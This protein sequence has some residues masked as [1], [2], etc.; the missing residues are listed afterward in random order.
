M[1]QAVARPSRTPPAQQGLPAGSSTGHEPAAARPSLGELWQQAEGDRDRYLGLLRDHG[2]ARARA[3]LGTILFDVLAIV[4]HEQSWVGFDDATLDDGA[5]AMAPILTDELGKHGYRIHDVARCIRPPVEELGRPMTP[6][7]QAQLLPGSDLPP[8][9]GE[10]VEYVT[11][12]G[13]RFLIPGG[14]T[15]GEKSSRCRSCD[16]LILWCVTRRQRRA[17]LNVDGTSHFASCPDADSWR[18]P[19]DD[20]TFTETTA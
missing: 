8:P 16:A 6:A 9:K 7:E 13:D 11:P 19:K 15:P 18:K 5:G 12:E 17:P 2:Y 1:T 4:A 10:P 14:Y 3:T 20:G